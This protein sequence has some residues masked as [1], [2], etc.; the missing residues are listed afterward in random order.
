MPFHQYGE[1]EMSNYNLKL[2]KLLKAF[3]ID[4]PE[5]KEEYD[6]L[7]KAEKFDL[8]KSEDLF[9]EMS[10]ELLHNKKIRF[11][12]IPYTNCLFQVDSRET[13]VVTFYHASKYVFPEFSVRG[14][15]NYNVSAIRWSIYAKLPETNTFSKSILIDSNQCQ[16]IFSIFCK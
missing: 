10:G 3:A 2:D 5:D 16:E 12:N 8:G 6:S 13:N 1:F 15:T 11:V 9:E 14:V 7:C 4:S